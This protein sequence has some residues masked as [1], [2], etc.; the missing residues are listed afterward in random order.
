MF[1]SLIKAVLVARIRPFWNYTLG[2]AETLLKMNG[3][4]AGVVYF[5]L[6]STQLLEK[7]G[8]KFVDV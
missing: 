8:S 3:A 2:A 4:C 5:D 1:F 6:L 7:A